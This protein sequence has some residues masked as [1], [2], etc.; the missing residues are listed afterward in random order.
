MPAALYDRTQDWTHYLT[1][2]F[3]LFQASLWNEWYR[4]PLSREYF[5]LV[6]DVLFVEPQRGVVRSYRIRSQISRMTATARQLIRRTPDR[7]AAFF[8]MGMDLNRQAQAAMRRGPSAFPDLATAV[9]FYCRLA[10]AGTTVPYLTGA[11]PKDFR[12][13]RP[14][15][16]RLIWT[17]RARSYYVP[18]LERVIM[19]LARRTVRQRFSGRAGQLLDGLTYRQLMG[20]SGRRPHLKAAAGRYFVYQMLHNRERVAWTSDSAKIIAELEP[21]PQTGTVR[22]QTAYP[23][24]VRGTARLVLTND[25]KKIRFSKGDILVASATNPVLVPLMRKAGA[26]VTD[27]GGVTCH[28]AII[29]RELKIPCVIGTRTA[30]RQL[31]DGDLVDVDARHGSITILSR[32][33]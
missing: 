9:D 22:G 27:E 25:W 15:V 7:A 20:S 4:H 28:A 24:R 10:I 5:G 2:P 11:E 13:V 31:Q 26:I 19:P 17:L 33:H 32:S 23:G 1:R 8:R 18:F 16:V 3:S 29:S 30:T 21:V 14:S 12:G 6:P